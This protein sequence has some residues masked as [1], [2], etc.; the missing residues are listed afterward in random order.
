LATNQRINAEE[1]GL[2]V[3]VIKRPP[4]PN[5]F[6]LTEMP[7]IEQNQEAHYS[8]F[9]DMKDKQEPDSSLSHPLGKALSEA[10]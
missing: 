9:P 3:P 8:W 1:K 2:Q 7:L 4:S 5:T 6:S 10:S